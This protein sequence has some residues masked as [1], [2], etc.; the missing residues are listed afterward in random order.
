MSSAEYARR[1]VHPDDLYEVA[2]EIKKSLETTDPN[3]SQQAEHRMVY[4]DGEVGYIIVRISVV[5]DE[6]GRTIRTF[7]VN[8]DI[9][10]RKKAEE[11]LRE[12]TQLNQVLLDAFPCVALLLR[13]HTRE[14]VASNAA[15]VQAGAVSGAHCFSTWG[16][17]E[18][19]CPW[20]LAPE[21]W[22]T[23][24]ARHLEVEA[25]GTVWDAHWIP[26]GRDLYMHYA[27]DVTERKRAEEALRK[28]ENQY[29]LLVDMAPDAIVISQDGYIIYVNRAAMQLL[30][31]TDASQVLGTYPVEWVHPEDRTVVEHRMRVLLASEAL[32]PPLTW[33]L[34]RR[35]GTVREVEAVS[36]SLR[37]GKSMI[38]HAMLR[39]ITERKRTEQAVR[40][41]EERYRSLFDNML[42]G[43]AYCRMIFDNGRPLDFVY[44]DVNASF[45]RLTGLKDVIGKKVT[46]VIPGIRESNREVLEA[47]GRVA[48]TGNPEKLEAYVQPLGIWFS[49]SVYS[50]EKGH[51]IAVFDNITERK[52]AEQALQESEERFRILADGAFEGVVISRDGVILDT[53]QVF[54]QMSGYSLEELVG[55]SIR[56]TAAPEFRDIA[57]RHILSGS[58]EAYESAILRKDGQ[59]IPALVKGK[60]IPYEGGTA[61]IASVRDIS[62]AR[63]AEELQRRLATAIEQSAEAVLITD[64]K[65]IIQYVNPA[66]ERNSGFSSEDLLGKTPRVFKSGEHDNTF[67]R[68]L[69]NTI[70]EGNIWSGR[71]VNKRKDGSLFQEEATISPVRNSAGEITNF[72]AVKRDITEHLELSNQ[73]FQAQKLEAVGTLA[74]GVAHDF[75]NLLQ[76]VLGYSELILADEELPGRYRDDLG[77]VNRAARNGADLV[78]RLLTFGR[79]TEFQP[80]PINLNRRIEQLQKMLSRTIPKMIEIELVLADEL[81]AINADPVQ[82]E[83][84][85][86][87][88]AINA[89]D[90]MPDGGRLVIETQNVTLDEQYSKTHL[91]AKPGSYVLLCV[92]DTGQ[93]IDKETLQHIF[94]PFFTT[95]APGE[96]TG[97]GLAMVYGIVKQHGGH[98]RC[99]SE[100]SEGTTFRIYFPALVSDE[101]SR[102]VETK[103]LP[104]GGSETVL[105]VDDEEMIRDLGARILTKAGYK[106]IMAFNGKE[107]LDVYRKRKDEIAIVILD[108]IMPEMGGKQCLEGLL[109]V[110]PSVNVVIASGYSASDSIKE[111]LALGAKGFVNKPYDIRQVLEVVRAVL[112][113]KIDG[114]SA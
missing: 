84:I 93:G 62:A 56:D 92:S 58:E 50:P 104:R 15:A 101:E 34:L 16:K 19:S 110:N 46:E 40:E 113:E 31:E 78:Q 60:T 37:S 105:I 33:R 89:R 102:Q 52:R 57:M 94:E 65:G 20:C 3:F 39:D 85:L 36:G 32:V 45:E 81:A 21:V 8:Q 73:L 95:K 51:F 12:R 4:A 28:S 91:D 100:R 69:W 72:V 53:N 49:V 17:R 29:R 61:R 71:L 43:F 13:P 108:L 44:L 41:S 63:K 112:D 98:I 106:A 68:Q 87:N 38:I 59:V 25:L 48:L 82:I 22:A 67:Y 11:E 76:V 26:V 47:Y 77:K 70:K 54:C 109:S 75:N 10:E 35:D 86:M 96:G 80:R 64:T 23:G 90:A 97:L 9:T 74:G 2:Y 55:M 30:G 7:G 99:Y 88:L 103:A 42:E 107:A 24:E 6:S 79:K 111:A 114:E 66:V 18:T 83:Q 27:F 14:I 1:F 5:K